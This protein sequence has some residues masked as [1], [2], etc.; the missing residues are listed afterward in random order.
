MNLHRKERKNAVRFFQKDLC[1][2]GAFAVR[3]GFLD[4]S[5]RDK[6]DG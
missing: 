5:S 3:N 1:V 2:L 4:I 6:I